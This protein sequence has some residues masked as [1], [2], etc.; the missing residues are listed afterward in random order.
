[1]RNRNAAGNRDIRSS[2]GPPPTY[3]YVLRTQQWPAVKAL[4][5]SENSNLLF[6]VSIYFLFVAPASLFF[7]QIYP[8]AQ[9]MTSV[10]MDGGH[11]NNVKKNHPGGRIEKGSVSVL[12]TNTDETDA[13][14]CRR[15]IGFA[16]WFMEPFETRPLCAPNLISWL[17]QM[18]NSANQRLPSFRTSLQL[19]V[20]SLCK[21][22]LR[23]IMK[24]YA[25]LHFAL[26]QP[27]CEFFFRF[28][29]FFSITLCKM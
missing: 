27:M 24:I 8:A 12:Y 22:F 23:V 17:F 29:L 25:Y 4:T 3:L 16:F 26:F 7:N 13:Q 20:S 11:N 15:L 9:R 14:C 2:D 28:V 18:P 5:N 21:G 19:W 6:F 10:D 1:M